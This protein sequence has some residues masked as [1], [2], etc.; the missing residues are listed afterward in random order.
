MGIKSIEDLKINNKTI[1]LRTDYNVPLDN[2]DI[3]DDNRIQATLDTINYIL[4]RNCKLIIISHLGRPKNK[5]DKTFS[6]EKIAKHLGDLIPNTEVAFSPD[7]NI[8]NIRDYISN[9]N[10]GNIILLENLRFYEE[11]KNNDPKFAKALSSL[12]DIYVNDAFATSHRSHASMVG[13][14][15]YIPGCIGFLVKKEI[16]ALSQGF[17]DPKIPVTLILGGSKVDTKAGIIRNYL[18][19]SDNI[20]LGGALANTFLAAKGY[21]IGKSKYEANKIG[22]A[23][24]IINEA[25]N[26]GCNL[27]TPRDVVVC[28]NISHTAEKFNILTEDIKDDMVIADIGIQTIEEYNEYI[29]SSGTIIWNGPVGVYEYESFSCGSKSI[30]ESIISSNKTSIIGGGDTVDFIDKHGYKNFSHIS[31]GGGAMIE[32]LEHQT[33]PALE[34]LK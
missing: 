9:M 11:E 21:C 20:L 13:I 25:I 22:L 19:N 18:D 1:I 30:A 34:V 4:E 33:L 29:R 24:Q 23:K 14:P 16:K 10:P 5:T 17:C 26:Y 3:S 15:R 27:M 31:T 12:A 32:F 7:I 8:E 6:L 28:S 2:N